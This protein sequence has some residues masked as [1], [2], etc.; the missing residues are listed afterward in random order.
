MIMICP[1]GISEPIG[2]LN[3]IELSRTQVNQVEEN[4]AELT[5]QK[6]SSFKPKPSRPQVKTQDWVYPKR[7]EAFWTDAK[8]FHQICKLFERP[9]GHWKVKK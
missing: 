2:I 7:L 4:Q 6:K 9:V 3:K 8:W 1:S 5:R